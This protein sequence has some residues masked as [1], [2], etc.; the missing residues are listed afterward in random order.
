MIC[1]GSPARN[2]AASQPAGALDRTTRVARGF[3]I[4]ELLVVLAI[5]GLPV[6]VTVPLISNQVRMAAIRSAAAEFSSD[7]RAA[8]MI[9][10]SGHKTVTVRVDA[11]P[12]QTDAV[13]SR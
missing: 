10:V 7:L 4:T 13:R 6:A 1:S 2:G 8:R 3:S 9:A 5:I 11:D 12:A